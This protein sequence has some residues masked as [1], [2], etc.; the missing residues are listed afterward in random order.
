MYFHF[1]NVI[2]T[3]VAMASNDD[4]DGKIYKVWK[5]L[6]GSLKLLHTDISNLNSYRLLLLLL[7]NPWEFFT[8]VFANGLSLEF[9]WQ[10]I[11][12]SFQDSSQYSGRF[13]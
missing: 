2:A 5:I 1:V 7:F 3:T 8:S 11:S 9:E 10:Q 4:G 12:S 6:S 13:Q